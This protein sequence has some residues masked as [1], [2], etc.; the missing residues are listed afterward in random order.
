MIISSRTA[1]VPHVPWH[2]RLR[3]D[4]L[5]DPRDGIV[6]IA[7]EFGFQDLTDLPGVLRRVAG[8]YPETDFDPDAASYFVS[9]IILRRTDA[10]GLASWRKRLFLALRHNGASDAEVLSLPEDRTVVLSTEVSL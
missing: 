1:H 7:A 5:G 9:R 10:P 2:R 3:V 8:K 4:R 6:H